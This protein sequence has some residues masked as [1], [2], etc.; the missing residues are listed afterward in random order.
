MTYL[1]HLNNEQRDAVETTEGPVLVLAGAGTGKTRVLTTRIAHL[2]MEKKAFP[3][4]ILSMTFTNKAAREMT[5]RIA[6]L[7]GATPEQNAGMWAGTFHAIGARI[8]RRHAERLGFKS[9]FTI[10]DAD[11]QERL[12]KQIMLDNNQDVKR[13]SPKI[14]LAIIQK[15]KDKGLRPDQL[16]QSDN[17]NFAGGMMINLYK[18]YQSRMQR[19]N[20][21]D[22]GDLILHPV[23]LFSDA[24][25]KDLLDEFGRRFKYILVDE[26]QDTNVAQYLWL[27]LL[28]LAQMQ[29]NGL[30]APNL[31]CVGDDDQ[32]I[33]S[34]RGAEVGNILRFEKDFPTAKIIRLETNYR[35]TPHILGAASGLIAHN[36][37]RLGKTLRTDLKEGEK[38][39][40]RSCWD[41]REEAR[42]IGEDIEALQREGASLNDVAILVRAGFQTLTF[43]KQFVS[44]GIPYRIVGG[45]RFYERKEIK[46][47]L[48]YLRVIVQPEDDLALER[49]IN[50]PKRGV[51]K[52][53]VAS[54]QSDALR[55]SQSLYATINY[56]LQ[57]GLLKGKSKTGLERLMELFRHWRKR[58]E[59]TDNP[60]DLA[61][62]VI[63][64]S[65]YKQ[66]LEEDDAPES[67]NRLDNVKELLRAMSEYPSVG[68]FLEEVA[69]VADRDNR[70]TPEE[71]MVTLMTIHAAKGLEFH[72]LFLPGWIGEQ[73]PSPRAIEESGKQGLEEERRLAYVALTRA[74]TQATISH[75]SSRWMF[76][77]MQ[78]CTPSPFL[79]ELPDEHIEALH[80]GQG[81]TASRDSLQ[82]QIDRIMQREAAPKPRLYSAPK[83]GE[84]HV[85]CK[86]S[87][88]KFGTGRVISIS[89]SNL[90]ICFEQ[91]GIKKIMQEFVEIA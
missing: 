75:P 11:D 60:A 49:I 88:T 85:G 63:N 70:D 32:S 24:E 13:W 43:E 83:E 80:D 79:K 77:E 7:M 84:I 50:T 55:Q 76:K 64:E 38:I 53:T 46:D 81:H 8:L 14:A 44:M 23:T 65:G 69:L 22:F 41:D 28:A 58:S 36:E 15:W 66:M 71:D 61:E 87:H 5:Q 4:Q 12:I 48:A 31:C 17:G 42:L 2:L 26:Y 78:Y 52:A 45:L 47:I 54:L 89:G 90:Q 1:D 34:W 91:A 51:G 56:Q 20:A 35:S 37:D 29:A 72:H 19:I 82:E 86:V 39:R 68:Q 16:S 10:L 40:L 67:E 18:Q 9:N 33:Y 6:G 21:M 74:R 25:N 57:D 73:F 3:G 62:L 27:R 30:D 59:A